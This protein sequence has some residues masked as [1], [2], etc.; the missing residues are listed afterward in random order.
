[1][2]MN[3]LELPAATTDLRVKHMGWSR[4][5]ERKRKLARYQALD[6]EARFG[7]AEQYASILDPAPNLVPWVE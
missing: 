6:P 4:P 2:P 3:V 7:S 5:E 1:M